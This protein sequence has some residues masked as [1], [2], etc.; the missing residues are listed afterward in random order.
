MSAIVLQKHQFSNENFPTST[1]LL[2][3]SSHGEYQLERFEHIFIALMFDS[4][5]GITKIIVF[6]MRN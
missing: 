4:F 5:R 3:W 2:L 6:F 1:N